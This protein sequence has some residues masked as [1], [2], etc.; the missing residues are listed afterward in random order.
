[1]YQKKKNVMIVMLIISIMFMSLSNIFA[2][3]LIG[4]QI[5]ITKQDNRFAPQQ[6]DH[7][8]KISVLTVTEEDGE[9]SI[10]QS[11]QENIIGT[12]AAPTII[13][14]LTQDQY[15]GINAIV[16]QAEYT[17]PEYKAG[18]TSKNLLLIRNGDRRIRMGSPWTSEDERIFHRIDVIREASPGDIRIDIVIN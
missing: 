18:L 7:P 17:I 4:R 16:I 2:I 9:S 3:P 6:A 11:V 13:P 1:M 8:I 5:I 12:P 10:Y 15:E 14:C